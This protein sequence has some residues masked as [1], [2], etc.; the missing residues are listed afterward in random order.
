MSCGKVV[1]KASPFS[2]SELSQVAG[3]PSHVSGRLGSARS[4]WSCS[5]LLYARMMSRRDTPTMVATPIVSVGR[6]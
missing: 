2:L 6:G 5:V 1:L 4:A 3:A